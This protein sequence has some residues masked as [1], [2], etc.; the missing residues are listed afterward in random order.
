MKKKKKQKFQYRGGQI[1]VHKYGKSLCFRSYKVGKE[2]IVREESSKLRA[3][4]MREMCAHYLVAEEE[5]TDLS[6]GDIDI[7]FG[8]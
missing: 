7:S 5:V 6:L 1:V 8:T 3:R 4:W 2:D